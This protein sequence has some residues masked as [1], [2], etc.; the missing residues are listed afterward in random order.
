M[1]TLIMPSASA[2]SVPG[3]MG[4][5]QSAFLAVRVATGS[6]TTTLAPRR[7]ASAM[8]GQWCRLLLIVLIAQSTMYLE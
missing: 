2:A 8:N 5:C 7:W 1:M 3:L 6:I 4:M